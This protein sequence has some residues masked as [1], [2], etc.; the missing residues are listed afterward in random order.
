MKKKHDTNQIIKDLKSAVNELNS[1]EKENFKDNL[2][3]FLLFGYQT[4]SSALPEKEIL[5]G[6]SE[7]ERAL[8]RKLADQTEELFKAMNRDNEPEE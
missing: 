8:I 6:I 1:E 5:K 2:L 7:N 3:A 4:S